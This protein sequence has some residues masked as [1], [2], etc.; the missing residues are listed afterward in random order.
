MIFK[1]KQ[2]R[3]GL[4]IIILLLGIL[5]YLFLFGKLFPYSPLAIGFVKHELS[6][7]VVYVQKGTSFN[8]YQEIDEIT[9][10]LEEF[11]LLKFKQK[12]KIYVF[13]DSLSYGRLSPSRAR[14]CAFPK[15]TLFISPWALKE[16]ENNEISLRTYLLHELSHILIFQNKSF[17]TVL[18]YPKWLLEGIAVYSS[19]QF[20]SYMYPTKEETYEMVS[21]GNFLEPMDFKTRKEEKVVLDV[22]YRMTFIY[23]E[24]GCIV[25]YLVVK[26]G[27]EKLLIY[28]KTLL[29]EN[30][31]DQVFQ[32][33]YGMKFQVMLRE[34]REYAKEQR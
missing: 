1:R 19:N 28:V 26:Y 10:P 21:K 24:F 13:R 7:S 3:I 20:G 33:I 29:K 17:L 23:A 11:F 27:K 18:Q 9:A 6:N 12:P 30:G 22:P 8:D 14:F 32:N 25:D 5:A 2:I 16:A 34:F 15:N 4:G 31:N